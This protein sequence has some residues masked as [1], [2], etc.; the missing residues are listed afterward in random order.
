MRN[1]FPAN[2]SCRLQEWIFKHQGFVILV[3]GQRNSE[4]SAPELRLFIA[5]YTQNSNPII[6]RRNFLYNHT[7]IGA[8]AF[9]TKCRMI[10]CEK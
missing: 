4:Y 3:P 8:L 10:K 9:F 7:A 2:G 5:A 1:K 6:T